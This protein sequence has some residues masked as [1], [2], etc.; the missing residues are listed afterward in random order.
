MV[1]AALLLG[2]GALQRLTTAS[3]DGGFLFGLS[4]AGV[5]IADTRPAV[6][7][8]AMMAE[9]AFAD[10]LYVYDTLFSPD[11]KWLTYIVDAIPK[12]RAGHQYYVYMVDTATDERRL[13]L[14]TKTGPGLDCSFVWVG[15][16]A[17]VLFRGDF[18]E[19]VA[20][21]TTPSGPAWGRAACVRGQDPRVRP[22]VGG[23]AFRRVSEESATLWFVGPEEGAEPRPLSG[24]ASVFGSIEWAPDG[25]RLAFLS[26]MD[27]EFGE[28]VWTVTPGE[29]PALL[30]AL[31]AAE[32]A[33][34]PNGREL[35]VKTQSD[36][37][38][39]VTVPGGGEVRRIESVRTFTWSP[40]G[41]A[42]ACVYL[43]DVAGPEELTYLPASEGDPRRLLVSRVA[44]G[45]DFGVPRFGPD[46]STVYVGGA[47]GQDVT[48]DGQYFP[49]ADRCLYRCDV[50]P[51]D[52]HGPLQVDGSAVR[53]VVSADGRFAVMVVES[54]EGSFLWGLD[55]TTG[56]ASDWG[57]APVEK[58]AYELAW[59]PDGSLI[60]YEDNCSV[61]IARLAPAAGG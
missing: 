9:G 20:R 61:Y 2:G 13:I 31:P 37:L 24:H 27:A 55:L 7:R 6:T 48:G 12:S 49:Q 11:G 28:A 38:V 5:R 54:T 53:P 42:L 59:S 56:A 22:G 47:G 41:S 36:E 39:V 34:S 50:G 23:I 32:I 51:S 4:P 10:I 18:A 29:D 16:D 19:E 44:D 52:A 8:D 17:P 1:L 58:Y 15:S 35:A 45:W 25:S 30:W 46:G 43:P 33:W 3:A 26:P 14:D 60:A 21:P 57:R 40:D